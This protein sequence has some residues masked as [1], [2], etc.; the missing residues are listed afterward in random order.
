MTA[1]K[2]QTNNALVYINMLLKQLSRAAASLREF[3]TDHY[4]AFLRTH[5]Y[6]LHPLTLIV[7]A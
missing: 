3:W 7:I 1:S 2:K 5:Q 6:T 4:G